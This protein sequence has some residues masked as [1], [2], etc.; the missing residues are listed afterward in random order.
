MQDCKD[1]RLKFEKGEANSGEALAEPGGVPQETSEI[2]EDQ[3]KSSTTGQ[4]GGGHPTF[5]KLHLLSPF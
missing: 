2:V 3:Q 5:P 4:M 1:E